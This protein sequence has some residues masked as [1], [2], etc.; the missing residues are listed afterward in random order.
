MSTGLLSQLPLTFVRSTRDH[1]PARASYCTRG[2]K[3]P[4]A[5]SVLMPSGMGLAPFVGVGLVVIVVVVVVRYWP[6]PRRL[7]SCRT[8]PHGDA[9]EDVV[10][11]HVARTLDVL[12][13]R[14]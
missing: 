2:R 1:R 7:G 3:S 4:P 5:V 10:A 11:E 13:V 9:R 14:G 8:A 12:L 6:Q